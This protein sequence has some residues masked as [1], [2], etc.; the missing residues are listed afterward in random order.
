M[1]QAGLRFM[2]PRI[3]IEGRTAQK[4]QMAS[5]DFAVHSLLHADCG[6]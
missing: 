3:S 6:E 1:N 5:P 2:N 4:Q